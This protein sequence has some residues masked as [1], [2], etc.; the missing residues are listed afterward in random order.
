MSDRKQQILE[1][2]AEL[3]THKSFAAFSYQD[4]AERL[5]IRKASIHHHFATKDDLG[6]ALLGFW[7][8]RSGAMMAELLGDATGPGDALTRILDRCEEVLLDMGNQVCP[9][10]AFEV[11]GQ[12][13]SD[14]V[15]EEL[16]AEKLT[17]LEQIAELLQAAR[18]AGEVAFLGEPR[19][20]A[21]TML[22]A[23]QGARQ[24]EPV[25][26]REFFRG[27]VRQLKRSLG[28]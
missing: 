14:R 28:L 3:L 8:E 5:G 27:V 15:R 2:A 17:F 22:A 1:T 26:G 7:R 12:A 4:L 19:D 16:K 21:A 18:G 9:A 23:L 20:Q 11:D 25:L 24:A 6:V 10:G 13:L